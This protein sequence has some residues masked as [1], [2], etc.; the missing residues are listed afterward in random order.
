MSAVGA[1]RDAGPGLPG[2][3]PFGARLAAAMDERGPLCVGIDPHRELLE[4][5]GLGDDAAGLRDFCLRVV[6]AVGGRVAAV[7]P[8]SAFF[9]RHGAAGIAV[10]EQTLAALRECGTPAVLDVKRG[11]IGSTMR[12][13]V[14]RIDSHNL[15][16]N[17]VYQDYGSPDRDRR[18]HV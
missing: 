17:R 16:Q 10:L 9:E 7:K 1:G 18:A 4:A 6:E 12:Q 5:W 11:D 15:L 3:P 8:Q 14:Y 13:Q 2:R